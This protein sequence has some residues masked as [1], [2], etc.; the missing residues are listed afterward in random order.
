MAKGI[1]KSCDPERPERVLVARCT[2]PGLCGSNAWRRR[3]DRR[4]Q[5]ST[6]QKI[7]ARRPVG[8]KRRASGRK[9]GE[10]DFY[11]RQSSSED[12]LSCVFGVELDWESCGEGHRQKL[13]P[14]CLP[15]RR[16]VE[17]KRKASGR[18]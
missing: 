7:S 16:P 3:S 5:V 6:S 8:G 1:A 4:E 17:G 12:D 11:Y 18:R 10:D 15:A 14:R 13:L 9:Q 2:E